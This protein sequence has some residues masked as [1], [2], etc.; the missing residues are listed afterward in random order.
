MKLFWKICRIGLI[1]ASFFLATTS[2]TFATENDTNNIGYSVQKVASN[3]EIDAD[4][5]FYDLLVT[6]GATKKIE[7]KIYNPTDKEIIVNS[8]IYTSGTNMNGEITYTAPLENIDQS[9]KYEISKF[10]EILDSNQKAV[11]PP[12]SN[13][14]VS[15]MIE[16]PEDFKEGVLLGSWYFERD[17]QDDNNANGNG[18][19]INNKY[20][21]SIAIKLTVNKEIDSPNLN[22]LSVAPSLNNYRKVINATIQNDQAAIVSNM[23]VK[24]DIM[25]QGKD[26]ILYSNEIEGIIMAPN[27]NYPFPVF[28]K[29]NPLIAG[30]YT[31]K[32][33]A[34][35][36]DPKWQ[37]QD[38]E[39]MQ[40]FTITKEEEKKL[41]D[42][43]VN[44][45]TVAVNNDNRMFY[46]LICIG[47]LIV[48]LLLIYLIFKKEKN[49]KKQ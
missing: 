28:L 42:E 24:A 17:G 29:S 39:W 35:T 19:N 6:P 27:S 18:I 4:S 36:E 14:I 37:S 2:S 12:H 7:A 33:S 31:M 48:I 11:I 47:L 45:S 8:D 49:K 22:L 25:K 5:S 23:R 1:S 32:L 26:D 38:W 3:D 43:A 34:K 13:K 16:V 40:D 10:S 41:N 21:Y 30:D 9:L 20:S 46:I 44:D 15:A